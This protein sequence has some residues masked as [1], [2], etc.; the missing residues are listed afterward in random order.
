MKERVRSGKEE[1]KK[2][3]HREFLKGTQHHL[4]F[5]LSL[6]RLVCNKIGTGM[7]KYELNHIM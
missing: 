4:Y 7:K 2:E 1:G 6:Y 5:T 3:K